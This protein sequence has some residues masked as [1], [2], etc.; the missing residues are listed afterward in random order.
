MTTK[1]EK[2]SKVALIC[3]SEL[4]EKEN[5]E[6][7]KQ[8]QKKNAFD[9][10]HSKVQALKD[11]NLPP[12]KWNQVQLKIMFRWYKRDGDDKLPTKKVD[13]LARYYETCNRGDQQASTLPS[14]PL[15][16][17]D[18]S[19]P[20]PLPTNKRSRGQ[21]VDGKDEEE[22]PVILLGDDDEEELAILFGNNYDVIQH[23]R[24]SEQHSDDERELAI[25]LAGGM[26]QDVADI[27]AV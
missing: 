4:H 7:E 11:L 19:E 25:L 26:R 6:Y 1:Q 18:T 21:H 22:E 14:D 23:Q 12:E 16:Q 27:T 10:L 13:Q 24:N 9:A 8:L 5:H 3:W 15:V 17:H 2:N 20:P